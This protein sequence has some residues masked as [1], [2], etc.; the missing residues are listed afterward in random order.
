MAP[1]LNERQKRLW[2]GSEAHSLGRGGVSLVARAT[3][4]SRPTIYKALGELEEPPLEGRV[5]QPGGGRKSLS[6]TD[7]GLAAALDEL[8]DPDSRGDPMS[9]LRW[10]CKSTGQLALA[11]TKGGHPV[12]ADTVGN[13]LHEAGFSLQANVKTHEGSQHP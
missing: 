13:M 4:V 3:G 6:Q 7:P 5:R 8:L 9:P 1:H 2:V 12:S 11:L 10:T